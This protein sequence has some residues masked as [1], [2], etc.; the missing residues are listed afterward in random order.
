[1]SE[2]DRKIAREALFKAIDNQIKE[3]NPPATK[4]TFDRL[5]SAGYSRNETMKYLASVLLCELNEMIRDK[6]MYDEASY[7]N[8]LNLLP[9]LPWE[10]EPE[11]FP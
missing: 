4:E 9:L 8:R 2:P 10:Y 3:G 5:I 1:M 6:R 7:V 11:D